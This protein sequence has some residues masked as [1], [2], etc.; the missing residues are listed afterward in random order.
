MYTMGTCMCV[1]F[2]PQYRHKGIKNAIQNIPL[3]LGKSFRI[4]FSFNFCYKNSNEI[5]GPSAHA[6]KDTVRTNAPAL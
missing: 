1:Y 3:T 4:F 5:L 6:G 2:L